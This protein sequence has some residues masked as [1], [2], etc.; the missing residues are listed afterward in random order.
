MRSARLR[1]ALTLACSLAGAIFVSVAQE[2][3]ESPKKD[4][5]KAAVGFGPPAG[6]VR[7]AKDYD[8]WLDSKNKHV[9]VDGTVVLREGLLEMFACPKQTKE[10]ESIVA[11]NCK[12]QFIH[13]GLI[14][15]GAEPGRPVTFDPEYKPASG[16]I[17]DVWVLWK[18]DQGNHKAP[19][20]DW[21]Q[22]AKSGK[23]MEYPFVFAG[24]G[25]HVDEV[26]G[27]KF[28]LADGGDMICVSNFTTAMLDVPVASPQDNSG[29]VF[30]AFT[31]K[32]PALGTPVRLVLAPQLKGATEKKV[33]P[34]EKKANTAQ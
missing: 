14:A 5:K 6:L 21:I 28:Y 18:D 27:E 26:S 16:P 25:F 7:L 8:I 34:S 29:L 32:I 20:Q 1:I 2:A 30:K 17:V 15:L 4:D 23:K 10:H 24:S 22:Q 31:E 9:V 12:A 11:V 19:A 13:A 33:P 3:G